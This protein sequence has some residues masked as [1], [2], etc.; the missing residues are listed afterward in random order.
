MLVVA[1]WVA[2]INFSVLNNRIGPIG[3]V[4]GAIRSK[5]YVDWTEGH[6]CGRSQI[7]QLAGDIS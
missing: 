4:Q 5:L 2:K 6:V 1:A 7:R 3:N